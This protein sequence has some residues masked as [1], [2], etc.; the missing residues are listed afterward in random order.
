MCTEKC[1]SA[2]FF[3]IFF[4][5]F[6]TFWLNL[7][8]ETEQKLVPFHNYIHPRQSQS[9]ARHHQLDLLILYCTYMESNFIIPCVWLSSLNIVF[10]N[11]IPIVYCGKP[12]ILI[13]FHYEIC[14]N[15][16]P[17]FNFRFTFW[18]FPLLSI[19]DIV[20]NSIFAFVFW[21]TQLYIPVGIY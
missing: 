14:G 12:A 9:E 10:V 3:V 5:N 15:Y 19:K 2:Q 17:P 1:T 8:E 20:A 4:Y 6:F 21:C 7:D 16:T 18:L 11:F 13:T